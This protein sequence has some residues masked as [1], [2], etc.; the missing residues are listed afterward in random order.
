MRS[1]INLLILSISVFFYSPVTHALLNGVYMG[2][3]LY[4]DCKIA[5]INFQDHNSNPVKSPADVEKS[6]TDMARMATCVAYVDATFDMAIFHT[7]LLQNKQLK[8][9]NHPDLISTNDYLATHKF[10]SPKQLSNPQLVLSVLEY[11]ESKITSGDR[12][13]LEGSPA[14]T[15]ILDSF[16]SNFPCEL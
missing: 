2:A 15:V 14:S 4:E 9:I 5:K 6:Y 3:D 13:Y 8:N 10:C 1:E 7:D 12:L 11:M 16:H